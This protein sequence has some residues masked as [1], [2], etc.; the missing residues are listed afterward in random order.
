VISYIDETTAKKYTVLKDEGG[1]WMA[2]PI[3][4]DRLWAKACGGKFKMWMKFPAPPAETK[5]I[6]INMSQLGSL[7]SIPVQR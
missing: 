7:D 6:T 4:R 2:G 5:S 1:Q 3:D